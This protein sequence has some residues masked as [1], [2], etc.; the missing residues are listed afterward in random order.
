VSLPRV[1]AYVHPKRTIP[2]VSGVG[3]HVNGM[4]QAIANRT[5]CQLELLAGR[6]AAFENADSKSPLAD[7]PLRKMLFN[8]RLTERC[9]KSFGLPTIES[10]LRNCDVLYSPAETAFPRVSILSAVTL[11]DIYP[12]DPLYPQFEQNPKWYSQRRRWEKWVPRMFRNADIVLTISEFSKSRMLELVNTYDTPIHVIG[13]GVAPIFFES[14]TWDAESMQAAGEWPYLFVIGGLTSRKGAEETLGVARLLKDRQSDVRIVVA[15]KSEPQW[16]AAA[17][18]FP[19][20]VEVGAIDDHKL[21]HFLRKSLSLLFLS[22]YEGFGIPVIE[23]MAARV[24]AIISSRTSL[25]E[26]G[27]EAAIVVDASQPESVVDATER[28]LHSDSYR[29]DRIA[30]GFEHAAKFTWAASAERLLQVFKTYLH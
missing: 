17:K 16:Q 25:P 21:I 6:D 1:L 19:N 3:R 9:W 14:Q 28:L 29:S 11:C 24:P 5:D 4:L 30:K 7:L 2:P 27:G 18:H 12:L 26:V 10:S 20:I 13:C 15:G 23:A 8:E 22:Q